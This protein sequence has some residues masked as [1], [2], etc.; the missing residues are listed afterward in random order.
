MHK[1]VLEGEAALKALKHLSLELGV[2]Q[3]A[4]IAEGINCV[5]AKHAQLA[6]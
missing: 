6:R 3:Q 4:L 5:L 1:L 2:S